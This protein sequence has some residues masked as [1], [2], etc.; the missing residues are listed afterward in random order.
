VKARQAYA[1]G[2]TVPAEKTRGEIE[3]VLTRYGAKGFAYATQE[4]QNGASRARIEFIANERRVRFDLSLPAMTDK[5]FRYTAAGRWRY[6]GN[7]ADA[8][9]RADWE[10]ET[11]RLWRALLLA[12]KAKLEVVQS[13]LAIF[14]EEFLANI[15]M[16]DGRTV[17]EHAMPAIAESYRR[18]GVVALLPAAPTDAEVGE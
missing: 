9:A 8:Q 10:A 18:G 12:I 7:R 14:E 1:A 17:G 6:P 16:P 11:R 15:V 5:R 3:T 13:G 4:G 2:T